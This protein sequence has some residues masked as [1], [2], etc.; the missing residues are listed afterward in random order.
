M[1]GDVIEIRG[2]EELLAFGEQAADLSNEVYAPLVDAMNTSAALLDESIAGHLTENGSVAS[3]VLR[4]SV[5]HLPAEVDAHT[6]TARVGVGAPYGGYV[7]EGTSAHPVPWGLAEEGKPLYEW[8]RLKGIAGVVTLA[9]RGS[10]RRASQVKRISRIARRVVASIRQSGTTAHPFF[11][12]AVDE[13]RER[14]Q[15]LFME[16]VSRVLEKIW[17]ARA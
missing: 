4:A 7:E 5:W 15:T 1:S 9:R 6:I 2:M 13:N 12:P 10:R 17:S 14:I 11:S 8:V 3:G 16:A